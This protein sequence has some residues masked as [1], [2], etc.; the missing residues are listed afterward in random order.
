MQRLEGLETFQ[1]KTELAEDVVVQ[2]GF[3]FKGHPQEAR[4]VL[5]F[6]RVVEKKLLVEVWEGVA[7][8][9]V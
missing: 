6:G 9:Q 1:G 7:L 3:V 4:K 5:Y 8:N 2:L